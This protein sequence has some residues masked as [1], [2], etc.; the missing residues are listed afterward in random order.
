MN[1]KKTAVALATGMVLSSGAMAQVV[2]NVPDMETNF[3]FATPATPTFDA[4]ATALGGLSNVDAGANVSAIAAS[5]NEQFLYGAITIEGATLSL[6]AIDNVSATANATSSNIEAATASAKAINGNSLATTVIGVMN[7]ADL[8]NRVNDMVKT[9]FAGQETAEVDP[10][11]AFTSD[12]DDLDRLT[13][14]IVEGLGSS[15]LVSVASN[16]GGIAG[17][18][19]LVA[20]N[21]TPQWFLNTDPLVASVNLTNLE[22][23]TTVIGAMNTTNAVSEVMRTLELKTAVQITR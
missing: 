1:F 11:A 9:D 3:D 10:A 8:E 14:G 16:A 4:I 21:S 5:V 6:G 13:T 7:T 12:L 19:A 17:N 22:A 20:S 15:E 2:I 18:I 23:S